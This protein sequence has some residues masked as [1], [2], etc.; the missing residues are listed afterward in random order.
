MTNSSIEQ[1]EKKIQ[2]VSIFTEKCQ[3]YNALGIGPG[4]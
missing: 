2:M 1:Q 3:K 4:T